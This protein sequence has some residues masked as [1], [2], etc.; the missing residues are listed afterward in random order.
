MADSASQARGI[1]PSVAVGL[2]PDRDASNEDKGRYTIARFAAQNDHYTGFYKT[3]TKTLNFLIGEQWRN[4]WDGNRFTWNAGRDIPEWR[5]QPVTNITFAVYRSAMAKLTK[6][7]PTLEVVPPSGNSEDK[8]A[9]DLCNSLLTYLWRL[10]GKPRKLPIAIGWILV[11]G[12]VYLRVGYDPQGGKPKPRTVPVP[13]KKQRLG[14]PSG[15]LLAA[16]ASGAPPEELME[17]FDLVEVAADED[18][19]PYRDDAGA[20]DYERKPDME[21]IGEIDWSI[22]SPLAVRLNPEATSIDDATEMFVGTL[23]SKKNAAKHFGV[24]EDELGSNDESGEQIALYADL[25]SATAAGFPRSWADKTSMY[26]VSQENAIG[27]R[28]LVIEY[29]SK[30]CDEYPEGRHWITAGNKKVWPPADTAQAKIAEKKVITGPDDGEEDGEDAPIFP[31]GEAPLPFGF[32]PPLV[33]IMDTPI[34]GQPS[35]VSILSQIVPLNEQLNTLDGKISEK[36][37]QDALGGVW[38][39]S[40]EDKG[41]QITSEPGQ[42]VFSNA[43]GRRGNSFAPFQAEMKAL[44]AAVYAER[45][46][47]YNKVQM[48]SGL[49]NNDLAQKPQGV[50]SGRALLV[51]Q[52]TSDS[53]LMPLLFS[54][55]AGLE[56]S[57]RRELVIAQQKYREERVIAIQS[58]DGKYT[59]RSFRNADLRDG[60]DVRVQVGSMFPWNKSAQWDAKMELIGRLPGLVTDPKTGMVDEAKLAKMLDSGAPGLGAFESEENPDLIEIN[61][62]HDLFSVY[63]PSSMD[64]SHQL[65]QVAFWQNSTIHLQ[66]HYNFMKKN[67]TRFDKWHPGAKAKFMEHMMLTMAAIEDAATRLMGGGEEDGGAAGDGSEQEGAEGPGAASTEGGAPGRPGAPPMKIVKPGDSA[68]GARL[69]RADRASAK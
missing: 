44:P 46:V 49:S 64:G 51:S 45:D 59:Y 21:R 20:I 41:I 12:I 35:A 22:V 55:E 26:G 36:H 14:D 33:P 23:W 52:E 53:V 10:L 34:P 56:E 8:E 24:P 17:D 5:Q 7:K 9:A 19:E 65:P 68:P 43:M 18:G 66:E 30:D 62:E 13:R 67:R 40:P 16:L 63:D 57:G 28:V 48:V 50:S 42:V 69:T 38:F 31:D 29:Y 47:I 2:P 37:V 6:Q 25:V 3:W 15:Q 54:L 32:W 60:H 39:A 4:E 11:T 27:D 58:T 61:S 1:D